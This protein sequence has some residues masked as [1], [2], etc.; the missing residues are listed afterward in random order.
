MDKQ[1]L[2]GLSLQKIKYVVASLA[3]P[4]FTAT[5]ITDWLYKKHVSSIDEMTNLSKKAVLCT[6]AYA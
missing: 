5:Q 2:F 6:L 1:P 4:S 3:L